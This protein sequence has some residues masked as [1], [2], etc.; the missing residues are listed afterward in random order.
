M[1]R[2]ALALSVVVALVVA[3]AAPAARAEDPKR[4]AAK[5]LDQGDRLFRKGKYEEALSRYQKAFEAFP[6][7]KIYYPMAQAE[8]NLE[9][10]VDALMHYELL[11]SEEGEPIPDSL[12]DDAK[13]RIAI[14][15]KH[16]V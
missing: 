4:A 8:E 3:A 11:V 16:V 7:A 15:E 5:L 9:R 13:A 6:S 1:S 10:W 12:R 14:V 2:S